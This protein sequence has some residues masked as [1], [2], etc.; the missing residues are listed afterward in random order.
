MHNHSNGSVTAEVI[1][2]DS[3]AIGAEAV[4]TRSITAS[5]KPAT[6]VAMQQK[7]LKITPRKHAT[8][9]P[10]QLHLEMLN[11][12]D[13]LY[14]KCVET[15]MYII[16]VL[17]PYCE[18]VIERYSQ[19][20][21]SKNRIDGKPTVEAYFKSIDL[22]YNTVRSWIH[23]R[24]L[25]TEMFEQ[26]KKKLTGSKSEKPPHLTQLEAKLLGTASA[27]HE[28]VKA[29]KQGGNVDAAI[30]DFERNAPTPER[31][32]EY[33]ERPVRNDDVTEVE[34]LAIRICK[35]IDKNDPK[36]SQ[37]ILELARELLKVLEPATVQH[38]STEHNKQQ[39]KDAKAEAAA[40]VQSSS[41]SEKQGTAPTGRKRRY[42]KNQLTVKNGSVFVIG[43]PHIGAIATFEG[44]DRND[45]AWQ[46]VERLTAPQVSAMEASAQ[47]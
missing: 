17:L 21:A 42:G 36:H 45:Q 14:S 34:K 46:E 26:P 44:E 30:R 41:R 12:R 19:P 23:R 20:G 18:E 24:R 31:I 25:Q 3:D 47:T 7:S 9:T 29:I 6:C 8:L 38:V 27:A 39:T 16:D 43:Y 13:T 28:M 5:D 37:T 4:T 40:S 22:N 15:E 10:D 32:E 1:Q 33:V 11:A 35:L 2:P